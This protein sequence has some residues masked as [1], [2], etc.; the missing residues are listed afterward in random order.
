MLTKK[1][2]ENLLKEISSRDKATETDMDQEQNANDDNADSDDEDAASHEGRQSTLKHLQVLRRRLEEKDTQFKSAYLSQAADTGTVSALKNSL[3]EKGDALRNIG[4]Q[5]ERTLLH[6]SVEEG[7]HQ[8]AKILLSIGFNPNVQEGCG[9]APLVLAVLKNNQSIWKSLIDHVADVSGPLFIKIPSPEKLASYL[10]YN[11]ILE[12]F[13]DCVGKTDDKLVWNNIYE[14]MEDISYFHGDFANENQQDA[15]L[16][17]F[18]CNKESAT[19]YSRKHQIG[20]VEQLL[21]I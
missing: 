1:E 4:D 2:H 13:N 19:G 6:A 10:G 7:Q 12:I 11:H 21:C 14:K 17:D 18:D 8:I 3:M 5:Y 9:A 16:L 20:K 15:L